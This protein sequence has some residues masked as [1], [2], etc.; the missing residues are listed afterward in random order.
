MPRTNVVGTTASPGNGAQRCAEAGER[1]HRADSTTGP[2]TTTSNDPRRLAALCADLVGSDICTAPGIIVRSYAP[3]LT[4]C[5]RLI[6]AGID[7]DRPL[8]VCRSGT[9]A[10]VVRSLAEGARLTVED[11]RLRHPRFVRWR[12]R[13]DGAA[14]GRPAPRG[15]SGECTTE[16]E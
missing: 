5:R 10:L 9:L 3:V 2:A 6:E 15:Q 8:R 12:S 11:N 13:S 4:L 1:K 16:R 14:P 7:P